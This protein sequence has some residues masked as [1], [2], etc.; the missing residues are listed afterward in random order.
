M[1]CI[2]LKVKAGSIHCSIY[3]HYIAPHVRG[4]QWQRLGWVFTFTVGND[5]EFNFYRASAQLAM[6]SPVLAAIGLSVWPSVTE[7]KW[8][9]LGSRNLHRQIAQGLFRIKSW[10]RNLK[11]SP[12]VRALNETE[13]G[14]ICNFQTITG[15][16]SEMTQDRTNDTI[17][18]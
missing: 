9:K 17:N 4:A 12:R 10:L 18:D 1:A 13:V 14:K 5:K 6:Q 3:T 15:H 11:G 16:I 7:W 2:L 8:R